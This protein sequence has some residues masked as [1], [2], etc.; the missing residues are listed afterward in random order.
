MRTVFDKTHPKYN[1]KK[2]DYIFEDEK[3]FCIAARL[4]YSKN[5]VDTRKKNNLEP[6]YQLSI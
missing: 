4:A 3:E 2:N 1:L 5:W 6:D